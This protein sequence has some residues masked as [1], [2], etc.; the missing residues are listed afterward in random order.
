LLANRISEDKS[1]ALVTNDS[2]NIQLAETFRY[3]NDASSTFLTE[4]SSTR[5]IPDITLKQGLLTNFIIESI[6]ISDT[7][8]LTDIITFRQHHKDEL[9]RFRIN[10]AR[11]VDSVDAANSFEAL[12]QSIQT[13][14]TDEFVPAYNDLKKALKA[15]KIK[16]IFD[17]LSKLCVFSMSTTAF[18]VML[19]ASVP[20]AVFLG[21]GVSAVSSVIAYDV[22]KSEKLR[23]NPYSYLLRV[24]KEL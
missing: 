23:N 18:P 21:A 9:A 3:D 16:W 7:T 24:D 6:R 12:Q 2:L 20:Q 14:Y 5:I 10:L 13:I 8:P 4:Y 17:N 19:G 11:L 1:I 22:D 15:S